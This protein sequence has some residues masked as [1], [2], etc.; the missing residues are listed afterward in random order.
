MKRADKEMIQENMLCC[1]EHMLWRAQ[2][3]I[4]IHA[5]KLVLYFCSEASSGCFLFGGSVVFI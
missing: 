4:V 3:E 1:T 5:L 2:K